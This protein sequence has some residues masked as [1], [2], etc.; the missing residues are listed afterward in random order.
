MHV[1]VKV[2]VPL[3]VKLTVPDGVTAV[4]LEVSVTVAVQI[5]AWFTATVTGAQLT[6]VEMNLRVTLIIVETE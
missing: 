5:V 2:P 3:V 4:P 1:P 6:D